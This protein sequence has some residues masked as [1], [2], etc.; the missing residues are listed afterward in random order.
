M[1]E[2]EQDK[3]NNK[4][5]KRMNEMYEMIKQFIQT[6]IEV[7]KSRIKHFKE[8]DECIS[9][10]EDEESVSM[11]NETDFSKKFEEEWA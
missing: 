3:K 5:Q 6:Q 7:N 9:H 8:F 11:E 2:K 1:S 4:E 10:D